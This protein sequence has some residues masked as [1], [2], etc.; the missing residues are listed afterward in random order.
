MLPPFLQPNDEVRILSPSGTI[1]SQYIDGAASTLRSWGLQ[2]SEGAFAR[3]AYGRFAATPSQRVADLQQ[4]LDDPQV[5]T[6]LCSRGG[7]GLAQIID[8]LD[9]SGFEKNPKWLIG[10]SDITVLHN[11][12]TNLGIASIHGPMAKPLTELS[13]DSE[14]LTYLRNILFGQLPQYT[15]SP[16]AENK[17]GKAIGRL[18]G[19]NLAVLM[20][21][22]GTGYDLD[23]DSKILFIEEIAED[24]YKIDRMIQNLRYGGVLAQLS[25]LVVGQF[26]DCA[27]DPLMMQ[28]ITQ[29]ISTAVADYNYPVCFNFPAGHVDY[30]L[31]LLLGA[32]V[33]LEVAED[34]VKLSF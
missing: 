24:P 18:V 17:K 21:M 31:S 16:Q 8:Q 34:Q 14:Q 23:F 20:G 25:G 5:K 33:V 4:A 12:I 2:V 19:G 26:S 3:G 15:F 29:I 22:R 28:S 30:N 1:D 6:I 11:A 32:N 27:E 13:A 9:F 7:Y 10:F